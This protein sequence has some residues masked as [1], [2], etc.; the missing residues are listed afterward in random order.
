MEN[1]NDITYPIVNNWHPCL[2]L[3]NFVAV[4]GLRF[5]N[6]SHICYLTMYFTF[7]CSLPFDM[8]RPPLPFYR[9]FS[10]GWGITS[11]ILAATSVPSSLVVT[12]IGIISVIR[13][14]LSVQ[15]RHCSLVLAYS[16]IW[17]NIHISDEGSLFS[18]LKFHLS[19]SFFSEIPWFGLSLNCP[20]TL[21]VKLHEKNSQHR[22]G[23]L[24]FCIVPMKF[25]SNFH[26]KK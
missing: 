25:G 20:K 18:E 9:F 4:D 5:N 7:N 13:V 3:Y 14:H 2:S 17:N 24:I 19:C 10:L 1:N 12:S 15:H 21:R 11:S 23:I 16:C 8:Y 6:N 22:S 26:W